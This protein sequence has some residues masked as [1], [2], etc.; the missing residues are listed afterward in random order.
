MQGET[1]TQRDKMTSQGQINNLWWEWSQKKN[2]DENSKAVISKSD[3]CTEL[4]WGRL[5]A[6]VPQGPFP[7]CRSPKTSFRYAKS[8]LFCHRPHPVLKTFCWAAEPIRPLRCSLWLCFPFG[9]TNNLLCEY[10][11]PKKLRH[12]LIVSGRS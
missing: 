12:T 5:T 2:M 4:R 1:E 6:E 8:F 7:R 11:Q 10:L 3:L 9:L